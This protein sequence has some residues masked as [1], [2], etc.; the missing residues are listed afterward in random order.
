MIFTIRTF[1][2]ALSALALAH[3][4]AAMFEDQA[5]TYDWYKQHVGFTASASF[6]PS[7]PRVCIS[8]AQA[9]VGCLNLRDGSIAWRK[10]LGSGN[11]DLPSSM[12][13]L[14]QTQ[15][16]I[17]A[18]D[19]YLRAFDLEGHLKWQRRLPSSTNVAQLVE[20]PESA[21]GA[22]KVLVLQNGGSQVFDA[23]EGTEL[24]KHGALPQL[25]RSN[26]AAVVVGKTAAVLAHDA[27]SSEASLAVLDDYIKGTA[28]VETLVLPAGL[29]SE[30]A[31]SSSSF[32]AL[33]AD[34]AAL[35]VTSLE[36]E[37]LAPTPV[38]C[39][40]LSELAPELPAS[41]S[42]KLSATSSGFVVVNADPAA[43][44]AALLKVEAGGD[45]SLLRH[46][47]KAVGVSP[48]ARAEEERVVGLLEV[49]GDGR[50]VLVVASTATGKTLQEESYPAAPSH[51][52]H[53]GQAPQLLPSG[54]QLGTFRKKDRS[55][56]FRALVSFNTGVTLFVQ[57]GVVV[58]SRDESLS[59]VKETLFV[60]LPA[61][62]VNGTALEGTSGTQVDLNT[63]F[64]YQLLGAKIQ[65]KLNTPAEAAEFTQLRG[66]LSDK[67]LPVRDVNGF[68][69]LLLALTSTGKLSA[70]H[71]GD[72]RVLWSRFFSPD[73][74][75]TRL[76]PWR[77]YHDI[78]HPPQVLL[79]RET[80]PGA[81]A[82]VL[83][84]HTGEEL[85]RTPL[86]YGVAKVVPLHTPLHEGSAE[87]S[88][89]LLVEQQQQ[90]DVS[91][92]PV[93]HLLPDTAASRS[94]VASLRRSLFFFMQGPE[95][96]ALQGFSLA[97]GAE[98]DG[99]GALAVVRVWELALPDSILATAARDPTEP[100]Q[101][102]V[103]VLSDRTIKYKYLNPNLLVVATGPANGAPAVD[104]ESGDAGDV[105]SAEV[106]VHLVDT[107]TGRV[108]HRQSHAGARGPVTAVMTE[109]AVVYFYR[110]LDSGRHVA[111][112]MELYDATNRQFSVLDY[113]FNPN[114]TQPVSSFATTPVEV[115]SQSFFSRVVPTAAAVTRTEQ[116]IT[117][118][119]LLLVTNTDQVYALGRRWVDPRRPK[120]QKLTQDEMEEGLLL[121][122]DTLPLSP[123]SF[124]TLDKQV[125][126]VR[127]TRVEP[128]RLESTCLLF[129]HGVDVFFTR[130]APAKGFDSLEDDFNYAL[131]VTLLAG[132]TVGA[133]LMHH[134]SKRTALAQK[135]K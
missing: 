78:Q 21:D 48:E 23:A 102:S 98:Q 24:A 99:S 131:L 15:L 110:D 124:A 109:N 90:Q 11:G 85:W 30:V 123:L 1:L 93:V 61:R 103:K 26:V 92:V 94:H 132:L 39:K 14:P 4:A 55:T 108:L 17:T 75:P 27:G 74:T 116:G 37:P 12:L 122:Q 2:L 125:L 118:K 20:I 8:T 111:T 38:R 73:S 62:G 126:G 70:L 113:L 60:D 134:M 42:R 77:S 82:A 107:V 16:L 115:I 5:G 44:G 3:E 117:A 120:K 49:S 112:S 69:K 57:Q 7:K 34:G 86:S 101:S 53:V 121:Y 52:R 81:Y 83:N 19:G 10:L 76:L 119:Q 65:L 72:G 41:Q 63:R 28:K 35:C 89:Y 91:S 33:T 59:A 32:A 87:Q 56:G 25:D 50:M 128:T 95:R 46:F 100:V 127:G 31:A 71:N 80:Q 54:V 36:G 104:P 58:W 29:S 79:L 133:V 84:A 64:R 47:P 22:S 9:V 129:V 40:P 130:L 105:L 66:A 43:P 67:N 88:L 114:S 13:L 68:R 45:V 106:T 97:A 6:H 135:W 96:G 18:V 51:E